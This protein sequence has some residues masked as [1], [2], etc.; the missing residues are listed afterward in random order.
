[1]R[2]KALRPE[3]VYAF[4]E[5]ETG[6]DLEF[7]GALLLDEGFH[8]ELPRRRGSVWAY[9]EKLDGMEDEL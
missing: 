6:E 2:L 4:H 9:R 1:M 7:S 3:A 8:F 5:A